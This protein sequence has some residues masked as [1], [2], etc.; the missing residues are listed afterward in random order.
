MARAMGIIGFEGDTV[1]IEGISKHRPMSS[2][3]FLGRYRL[4]DFPLS[5][6]TNSGVNTIHIYVKEKPR[7]VFEH[8][9]TG[10]Q[11]NINSKH[12]KL[13]VMYGE[14]EISSSVYNT[15]VRSYLQNES[16]IWEDEA[17]Y[18]IIMPSHF[19]Y[20]QNFVDVMDKHIESGADITMLY[21]N[22]DLAKE[23]YFGTTTLNFDKDKRVKSFEI[24]R[25]Q[26]KKRA[27]SLEAYVMKKH[28]FVEL[29]RKANDQSPIYWFKDIL[30]ENVENLD[31]RGYSVKGTVLA[32]T[33]LQSYYDSSMELINPETSD[34]FR[35]DWPIYTR[36]NDSAPTIY[37]DKAKVSKSL[38]AN[39][40]TIKGKVINSIIGRNVQIEEGAVVEN[41]IILPTSY[42]G[43]NV[44]IN[45]LV[46]DKH[47]RIEKSKEIQG[48]K[49]EI[50]YINRHDHI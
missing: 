30:T 22:T 35:Q 36:T 23:K 16:Y 29:L 40:T 33:D 31:I 28:L 11:Y 26:A 19:V 27:I 41:C 25:G 44:H 38:V 1:K 12:G 47:V 34:L 49:E 15:D 42:V 5:N 8:V 13:R 46:V 17:E 6:L 45:G 3:S 2:V 10:R 18:V 43:K 14:E 4:I 20:L 39:G 50:I 21:K 24:N 7:S 9:G 37:G 48:S 32:I